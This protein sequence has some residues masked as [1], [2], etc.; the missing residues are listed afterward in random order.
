MN[1]KVTPDSLKS[2]IVI[3]ANAEK[4][5]TVKQVVREK[6]EKLTADFIEIELEKKMPWGPKDVV[7]IRTRDATLQ[8]DGTIKV[9]YTKEQLKVMYKEQELQKH[10]PTI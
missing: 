5:G 10:P 7:K 4:V 8:A 3:G 6:Y 1:Q 2:K 9:K